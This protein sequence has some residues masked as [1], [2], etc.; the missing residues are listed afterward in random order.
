MKICQILNLL[1]FRS[2]LK[3]MGVLLPVL[4]LTWVVGVFAV[5]TLSRP[6]TYA[7]TILNTLQVELHHVAMNAQLYRSMILFYFLCRAYLCLC[8][9]V[10]SMSRYGCFSFW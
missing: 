6:L 2:G 9:I 1:C 7:F 5:D 10:C 4:G 3:A 8:F